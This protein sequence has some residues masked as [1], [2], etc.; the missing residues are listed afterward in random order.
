MSA[1]NLLDN[2]LHLLFTGKTLFPFMN[3]SKFLIKNILR[4]IYHNLGYFRIVYQILK[5]IQF[6][7]RI[8]NLLFNSYSFTQ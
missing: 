3:T 4:S 8:K 6:S 7:Q 1:Y 2:I 5:C